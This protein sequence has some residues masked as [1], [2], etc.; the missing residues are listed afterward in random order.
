L[1]TLY[2][3]C[4][5]PNCT[6][7]WFPLA[8]LVQG[9]DGNFYGTTASGGKFGVT[10]EVNGGTV[11]KITSAGVLTT[12]YN[13]CSQ[14]AFCNDG[15]YPSAAL[16]QGTDGNFY[17]TTEFGGFAFYC[18]NSPGCGTVFMVTPTGG[19]ETTI[20]NFCSQPNC[21]DGL[22]AGGGL[23]RATDGNFYGTTWG[24]PIAMGL[25]LKSRQGEH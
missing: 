15:S 17:G 9:T 4:S 18:S 6:D 20:Y 14:G 8:A 22:Q 1:T 23:V 21:T 11:F 19:V 7:G 25:C 5:Q 24:E 3:F 10:N 13:F 2:S 12:L 16:V